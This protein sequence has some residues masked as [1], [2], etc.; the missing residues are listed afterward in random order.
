M[1]VRLLFLGTLCN[2]QGVSSRSGP[3]D[4]YYICFRLH[5]VRGTLPVTIANLRRLDGRTRR[6]FE[7]YLKEYAAGQAY[8]RLGFT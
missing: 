3:F 4:E 7:P 2:I 5:H 1:R 8:S 6:E